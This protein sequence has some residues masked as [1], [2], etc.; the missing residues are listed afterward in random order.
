MSQ[1]QN[2]FDLIAQLSPARAR[3]GPYEAWLL[4]NVPRGKRAALE[5]GCGVGDVSRRLSD[6]FEHVDA[7]DFSPGM[8][9]EAKRR[10][11]SDA[12]IE[13]V[14]TDMFEWLA[15]HP[16][17]YDCIVSI[18]TLHHVDL[19]AALVA[20]SQALKPGGMLLVI[21][22][23]ARDGWRNMPINAFAKF[24]AL[25]REVIVNRGLMPWKLRRAYWQHGRNETYLSVSE[26]ERI[27]HARLPGAEVRGRLLWRYTIRWRKS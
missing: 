12:A 8:I 22:L 1:I 7:I 20:M 10:T 26:V 27:A 21:D 19:D 2:D 17:A 9:A 14:C 4:A 24:V 11:T 5:I 6:A 16:N 25:A 15:T 23:C 3:V 18:A 13:Y